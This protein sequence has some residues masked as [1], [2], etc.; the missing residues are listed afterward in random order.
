MR[1][2][3]LKLL[4]VVGMIATT[5]FAGA[6]TAH[7]GLGTFHDDDGNVHEPMIEA[8]AKEGIT[9]GQRSVLP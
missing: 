7:A 2:D 8:I 3:T 4:V 5:L 6:G 1:G 9:A